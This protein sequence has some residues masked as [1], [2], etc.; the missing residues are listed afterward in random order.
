MREQW[1]NEEERALFVQF[2]RRMLC[3]LLEERL[4][5]E[6]AVWDEF[7]FSGLEITP[8]MLE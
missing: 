8:E 5:A 4:I 6:D 1:L 3:W 7:L 2:L